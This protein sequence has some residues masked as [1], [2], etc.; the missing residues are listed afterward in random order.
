MKK[1]L[2]VLTFVFI[3]AFPFV[4]AD[5]SDYEMTA[6]YVNGIQAEGSTVQ[7]ELGTNAQIQIY[8]QGTGETTDVRVRAWLGGYEYGDIEETTEVFK[9]EDGVS[10]KEFLYLTIPD[11]LDVS[12]NE[13]TLHVEIYDGEDKES[14]EYTL[15]LEQERHEVSVEDILLSSTTVAPGDYFGVKVRLENQGYKD[16]EDVKVTVSIPELGISNRVYVDELLSGDQADAS[17]AYLVIPSDAAGAYEVLVTVAYNNGY[18]EVTGTSY[19]RVE[20]EQVYD[21]NTFVSVSSITGLTVGET[22]TYKVQVTNL[23]DSAKTFYLTVDGLN[24]EYSSPITVPAQSSGQFEFTLSPES[25]G[26]DSVFVEITT[27]EGLVTQKLLS[28]DVAEQSA[29]W[30]LLVS[31]LLA[32]LVG[33]GV[34]F[35]LRKL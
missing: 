4:S 7:V 18:S 17:T 20:G 1:I 9:V 10:Y 30:V 23:A 12:S 34:L 26:S 25:A 3:L 28:V 5:S 16:E 6:V 33:L 19:I 8:V 13:Y 11:D 24:A 32:V 29:S 22:S 27:D 31:V 2:F 14:Q 35:Y 15:Y 21:E